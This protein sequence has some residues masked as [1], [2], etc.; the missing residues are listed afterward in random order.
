MIVII[1]HVGYIQFVIILSKYFNILK[2][3]WQ[4]VLIFY[5]HYAHY[6]EREDYQYLITALTARYLSDIKYFINIVCFCNDRTMY[7]YLYW[8]QWWDR[9]FIYYG[10]TLGGSRLPSDL[11]LLWVTAPDWWRALRWHGKVC[12]SL[13]CSQREQMCCC[14]GIKRCYVNRPANIPKPIYLDK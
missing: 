1:L 2:Y 13:W 12:R 3:D 6:N 7:I 11:V 8:P 14:F 10:S 5:S 9:Y 4:L